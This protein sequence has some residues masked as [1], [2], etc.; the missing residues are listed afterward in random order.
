MQS[1]G[2][3]G[4][5]SRVRTGGFDNTHRDPEP[6]RSHRHGLRRL[7]DRQDHLL[8][9]IALRHQQRCSGAGTRVLSGEA[10]VNEYI[11]S[12]RSGRI[13]AWRKQIRSV[14][15]LCVDDVT[16]LLGKTAT[17][18]ELV[19]TLDALAARGARACLTAPVPPRQVKGLS[20][21][22]V[23]RLLSGMVVSID[24]PDLATREQVARAAA[25]RRGLELDDVAA[26][27][28]ARCMPDGASIRELEG[29]VMKVEAIHRLLGGGLGGA[30]NGIAGVGSARIGRA[31]VEQA[32]Q[33][34]PR[35]ASGPRGAVRPPIR[36]QAILAAVCT[37]IGVSEGEVLSSGRHALVVVARA[38]CVH[39][40]RQT[41]SMS[42]PE[43]ARA[44][45]RPNHSTVITAHQRI[46]KQIGERMQVCLGP[47]RGEALLEDLAERVR[48]RC[49]RRRRKLTSEVPAIF[50]RIC[51]GSPAVADL[52]KRRLWPACR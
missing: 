24:A 1:P 44:L 43:I 45:S 31:T 39:T 48:R 50:F 52:P 20:D 5:D 33:S 42:F 23:S 27:T 47:G 11:T 26:H 9:G 19:Y 37:I 38:L 18:Q 15:L 41:T 21:A 25:R 22:L 6:R 13:D 17:Q 2:V 32:L 10:F 29:L 16:A 14:D 3:R 30:S 4:G 51:F 49:A 36:F 8:H 34:A 35:P 46:L 28:L 40:A 7:R 12:V